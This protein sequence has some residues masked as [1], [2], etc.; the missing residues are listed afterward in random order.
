MSGLPRSK[1][2]YCR[3]QRRCGCWHESESGEDG[4]RSW[5]LLLQSL[6]VRRRQKGPRR[7]PRRR[8]ASDEQQRQE[9]DELQDALEAV[10]R[11]SVSLRAASSG[12]SVGVAVAFDADRH[13]AP[14]AHEAAVQAVEPPVCLEIIEVACTV[15]RALKKPMT[16]S[17]FLFVHLAI[18][19]DVLRGGRPESLSDIQTRHEKGGRPRTPGRPPGRVGIASGSTGLS[20]QFPSPRHWPSPARG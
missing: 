19:R 8:C 11:R 7:P 9:K 18:H 13:P 16:R 12:L 3:D 2:R 17:Q 4:R 14:S 10:M 1:I 6:S 5:F 15:R 20:V